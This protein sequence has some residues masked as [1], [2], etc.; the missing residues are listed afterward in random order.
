MSNISI[1]SGNEGAQNHPAE[2]E[3]EQAACVLCGE[4]DCK[5]VLEARD[6]L[7]GC[8][9][10]FKL[11]RCLNCGH[12]YL[13]PRPTR[14]SMSKFY[15]DEY[16]PHK[17]H[18]PV[19]GTA[20]ANDGDISRQ[21]TPW[22]LSKIVRRI[23]GLRSLYYW[24]SETHA[25][26]IPKASSGRPLAL[27]LG[28]GNGRFLELLNERGWEAN[29]IEAAEIPVRRCIDRGLNV[30]VE[31]IEAMPPESRVYDAVFAWMVIE[32]LHD[33]ALALRR[34]RSSLKPQGLL[35]FSVPN[36]GSWE[37]KV[38]G[39][40]WYSLQLPTHLNHFSPKTLRRLLTQNG[41]QVIRVHHQQNVLNLVGSIGI[42]LRDRFPKLRLGPRLI[43]FTD[44]PTMWGRLSL[45][46]FAKLLSLFRQGGR[47]TV[48][49]CPDTNWSEAREPE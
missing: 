3:W 34:I 26:I 24:A 14:A 8:S 40:Y 4:E 29:G 7:Y 35:L 31:D 28:C 48:I 39:R 22:Y 18:Q 32:H 45:S 46:P 47:L 20:V 19:N 25:E 5:T 6:L 49:A 21:P 10:C 23:P 16:G 42:W 44:N 2:V 37:A 36:F 38:F 12:Y 30:R 41:F 27:E 17:D 13:A 43:H 11:V 9:G 33:P 15:P 1:S